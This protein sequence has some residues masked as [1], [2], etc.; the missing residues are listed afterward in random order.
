MEKS[1]SSEKKHPFRMFLRVRPQKSGKMELSDYLHPQDSKI[2]KV[3]VPEDSQ[4]FVMN[5]GNE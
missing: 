1:D 5:V 4:V 3:T 2:L